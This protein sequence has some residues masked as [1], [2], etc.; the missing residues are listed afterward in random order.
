MKIYNFAQIYG[1]N[2]ITPIGY[3]RIVSRSTDSHSII[4]F[5]IA[6]GLDNI[7]V[8]RK[9]ELSSDHYPLIFNLQ[10][11]NLSPPNKNYYKFTNWNK[12]QDILHTTIEDNPTITSILDLDAAATNFA[13]NIQY[14]IDQSST[15]KFIPHAPLPLPQPIR[16]LIQNK[17]RLRKRWQE[18]RDPN[19]KKN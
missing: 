5:G 13:E 17:N 16:T 18:L 14:T 15:T 19:M 4:D 6:K 7:T 9:E 8:S 1:L 2:L 11:T 12:F 10:P 3:T